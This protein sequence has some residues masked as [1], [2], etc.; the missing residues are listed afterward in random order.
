MVRGGLAVLALADARFPG[1][2][3]VHSGGV[4]EAA[5]RGLLTDA[6]QLRGFLR[7]RLVGAGAP[8]AVFAAASAHAT[9]RGVAR[10]HW[11]V[12]DVEFDARTPSPAQRAASRAQGRGMLRAGGAAW[13]APALAE[14]TAAVPRPHQ[15]IVLGVLAAAAGAAPRDA[16]L[17]AGY[18][19][20]SGAASAAVRLLGLDPFA[21]NAAVAELGTELDRIADEAAA[22]A[23]DDPAAL[24]APGS[25]AL[26][27][28]AEAHD[29][30][31]QEE[32]RL[33][34]S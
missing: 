24:P 17:S 20:L 34:A 14:L 23:G 22:V 26:D 32:V 25:P 29:R 31:H 21:A 19:A 28:L 13:P 6:E 11:R 9:A 1:G 5:A 7:G 2:G 27:L 12:L 33:F 8:Q 4:E 18:L 3:H 15:P 10:E 30:H 16:A